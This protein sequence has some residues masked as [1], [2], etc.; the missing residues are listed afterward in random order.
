MKLSHSVALSILAALTANAMIIPNVGD[1]INVFEKPEGSALAELKK[2]V[3]EAVNYVSHAWDKAT[4]TVAQYEQM[5]AGSNTVAPLMDKKGE[6]IAHKYLIIFKD[7]VP[8]ETIEFHQLFVTSKHEEDVSRADPSSS[9]FTAVFEANGKHGILDLFDIGS[10]RGYSG[11]FVDSTLDWIRRDPAVEFVEIDSMVHANAKV[12]Q[13][14]APWGLARISTRPHLSLSNFNRYIH[15]ERGGEGVTAYVIDTGVFTGHNQFEGRAKWGATIP[16]DDLDEDGNGHGTHCA[17]TIASKDFGVAKK[18]TVVG[19]KVLR[20]NGSGSMTDVLKGVEFVLK[21]HKKAV[22]ERAKGFKG[23]T[24]N[25]SLGG[26]YSPALDRAVNAA[27]AGGVHFAVA[28][29]NDNQD[30]SNTSPA[31]SELVITVGAST[32]SDSRAFFSN[33]GASVDVFAPGLNVLSTYIGSNSATATLSGTSMASPH[34][35]GLLSFYVSLQPGADSEYFSAD[36]GVTTAQ[37]KELL[38]KFASKGVLSDLPK[39]KD[40]RETPNNLVFNGAGNLSDLWASGKLDAKEKAM[41]SGI[42]SLMEKFEQKS[43]NFIHEVQHMVSEL[44]SRE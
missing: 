12:T 36:S 26:D 13:N 11:Y 37:L 18:A 28:A 16:T 5:L 40:N 41:D 4:F 44:Y 17:G 21:S 33:Y 2:G 32:I 39:G 15:D 27:V 20:S 1:V 25:L 43:E 8:Q 30:A 34:V 38:L 42:F 6:T 14:G 31:S 22:S 23:S 10:V 19:V 29:G 7:D 9:F 35:C 24:A 3:Q